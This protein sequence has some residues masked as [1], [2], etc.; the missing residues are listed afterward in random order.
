M[1]FRFTTDLSRIPH[2]MAQV[3]HPSA[4]SI[5]KA[6]IV[7]GLLLVT[8]IAGTGYAIIRSPYMTQQHVVRQQPVQFSHEHHVAGL[9]ID[10]RYCHTTVEHSNYAGMPSTKTCMTCHS[11]IW[12]N[13]EMLQTVR[14][15]WREDKPI[16]WTRVHDVPDFVQFNHSIHVQKGIGCVSCH[17]EVDKMPLM[18]KTHSMYMEWCLT[19]HRNPEQ[20]VRP[21]EEVFN[22]KWK[23]E[24]GKDPVAEGLK[25][26]KQYHIPTKEYPVHG[27]ANEDRPPAAPYG[28]GDP[29]ENLPGGGPQAG[30]PATNE[31]VPTEFQPNPLTN[32]SICHY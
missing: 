31:L 12:T 28:K 29:H 17:G 23:W 22:L 21:R 27:R 5:A 2:S 18:W 20:Y 19:C 8:A 4:N 32:C 9:G 15:S 16:Q 7:G 10:C 14:D 6:S 11:Q 25:L 30:R 26:L 24:D 1:P 3:F 13:A